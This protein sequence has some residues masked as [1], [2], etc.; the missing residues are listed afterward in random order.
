MAPFW[1]DFQDMWPKRKMQHS[2]I[3]FDVNLFFSSSDNK[4]LQYCPKGTMSPCHVTIFMKASLKGWDKHVW[5]SLSDVKSTLCMEGF[6]SE[7]VSV[8]EPDVR[9]RKWLMNIGKTSDVQPISD[10]V[11]LMHCS[12]GTALALCWTDPPLPRHTHTHTSRRNCEF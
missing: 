1:V 10:A 4:W 5:A 9:S 6:G 7:L 3:D 8:S 2:E 11:K 12:T